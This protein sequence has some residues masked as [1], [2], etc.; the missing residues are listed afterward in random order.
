[1]YTARYTVRV[2]TV[3]VHGL[4]YG[5]AHG[6]CP[7]P[8]TSDVHMYTTVYTSCNGPIHSHTRP[9]TR[10]HGPY[11]AMD[12][13]HVC[14][15]NRVDGRVLGRDGRARAVYIA[16]YMVRV[17][18]GVTAVTAVYTAVNVACTRPCTR[19]HSPYTKHIEF[20]TFSYP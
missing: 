3:R 5:Y 8:C 12:R 7:R 14:I 2:H 16:M 11:T 18:G 10:A 19:I 6:P 20:A 1:M 9:C 17:H 15:H 13:L 4:V